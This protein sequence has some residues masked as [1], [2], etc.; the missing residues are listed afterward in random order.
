M[1]IIKRPSRG[2][3]DSP[4]SCCSL[5]LF[6]LHQPSNRQLQEWFTQMYLQYNKFHFILSQ[7]QHN[8][9]LT[10]CF[11]N[12]YHPPCFSSYRLTR[13]VP[14]KIP[15]LIVTLNLEVMFLF[16]GGNGS[17]HRRWLAGQS[18]QLAHTYLLFSSPRVCSVSWNLQTYLPVMW[19]SS[20]EIFTR[21]VI[22]RIKL[23][24]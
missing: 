20:L 13:S 10:V 18:N 8:T 22:D 21:N 15:N 5:G 9:C 3:Y 7:P 2:S 24:W 16:P 12:C 23:Q 6:A 17:C 4:A 14:W 19:L 11:S 1:V